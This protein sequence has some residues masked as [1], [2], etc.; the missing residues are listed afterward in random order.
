[1]EKEDGLLKTGTTTMGIVCKDGIVLAA[2]KRATMGNYIADRKAKKIHQISKNIAVT[3]AGTVSD[4]QLI[5]KLIEAQ[6]KLEEMRK[7][8][9]PEVKEAAN[10]LSSIVYNNIRKFSTIAGVTH[11]LVGGSDTKGFHLYEVFLDGSI[12][13]H[14]NFVSS[15]SGS[16]MVWGYL[17]NTYEKNIVVE[18]GVKLALKSLN[19]AIQRDSASGS[20]FDIVK[21]TKD[22]LTQVLEKEIQTKVAI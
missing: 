4:A 14:E 1:M 22:G 17:E 16:P 7:G 19:A 6:L 15:G 8:R 21:I 10:L 3:I 11:F 18:D 20:G 2:D 5:L 12:S 13:E 9:L